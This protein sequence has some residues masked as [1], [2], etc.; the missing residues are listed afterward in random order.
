M[1]VERPYKTKEP[2][3]Y[4]PS[5]FAGSC[6]LAKVLQNAIGATGGDDCAAGTG[7]AGTT[8]T[9]FTAIYNY[10]SHRNITS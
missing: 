7:G 9:G 10:S 5:S 3:S 1:D 4:Q 6:S 8:D 2:L